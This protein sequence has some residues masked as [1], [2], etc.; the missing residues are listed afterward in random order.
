MHATPTARAPTT[1]RMGYHGQLHEPIRAW[2]ALGNGHR[3]YNPVLMRFHSADD[4]S[5]FARGGINAYAGFEDDPIN[6]TDPSGQGA[7]KLMAIAS[8]LTGVS[9]ALGGIGVFAASQNETQRATAVGQVIL[10]LSIS[11]VASFYAYS[12]YRAAQKRKLDELLTPSTPSTP[13]SPITETSSPPSTSF[14]FDTVTDAPTV[15]GGQ[16]VPAVHPRQLDVGVDLTTTSIR[17]KASRPRSVSIVEPRTRR[18]SSV[19]SKGNQTR[20]ASTA[21]MNANRRGSRPALKANVKAI[22]GVRVNAGY[23]NRRKSTTWDFVV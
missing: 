23:S 11:G 15:T 22:R 20:R 12:K 13:V 3:I 4:W 6:K 16:V 1:A 7:I 8:F 2:Q 21:S 14:A 19:P 9:V 17:V 10:G 5:P 18:P